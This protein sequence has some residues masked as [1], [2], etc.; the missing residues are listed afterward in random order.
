[1]KSQALCTVWSIGY[2]YER[3]VQSYE[4][5]YVH[6]DDDEDDDDE[7]P[8]MWMRIRS[9]LLCLYFQL[10]YRLMKL[11]ERVDNVLLMLG[12]AAEMVG[13][14]IKIT[15]QYNFDHILINYIPT[16]FCDDLSP[17]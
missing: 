1:M 11:R 10:Y 16:K 9:L 4:D 2:E 12:S 3:M 6:D 13:L 15:L 5:E 7:E 17:N 8:P 14:C